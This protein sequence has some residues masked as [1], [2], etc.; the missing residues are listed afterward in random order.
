MTQQEKIF[1]CWLRGDTID[2][3]RLAVERTT[4]TKPSFEEVRQAFADLSHQF[5]GVP[6]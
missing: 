4:G 5:A 3:C 6:A 1:R 2:E